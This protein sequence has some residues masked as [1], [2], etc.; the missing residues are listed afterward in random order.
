MFLCTKDSRKLKISLRVK[1]IQPQNT[2]NPHKSMQNCNVCVCVCGRS[3]V[4]TRDCHPD[5]FDQEELESLFSRSLLPR[6]LLFRQMRGRM[7]NVLILESETKVNIFYSLNILTI[8][9]LSLSLFIEVHNSFRE[10]SDSY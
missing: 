9:K 5:I 1:H 2:Q 6:A 3:H 10:M 4:L 7:T 8:R